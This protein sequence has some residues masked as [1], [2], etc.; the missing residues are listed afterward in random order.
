LSKVIREETEDVKNKFRKG[1]K[2]HK[3]SIVNC[4]LHIIL[5]Y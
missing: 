5:S 4:I 3:I 2:N 1:K